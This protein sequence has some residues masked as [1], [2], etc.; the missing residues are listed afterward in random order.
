M[1]DN[2]IDSLSNKIV[3]KLSDKAFSKLKD[4]TKQF[5]SDIDLDLNLDTKTIKQMVQNIN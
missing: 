2:N 4:E 5:L 1:S 3:D